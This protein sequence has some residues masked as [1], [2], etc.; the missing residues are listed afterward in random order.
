MARQL[1]TAITLAA[2][3]ALLLI[4]TLVSIEAEASPIQPPPGT[5]TTTITEA[6]IPP[7]FPPEFIP[8]LVG[9][10]ESEFTEAGSIITSKD[11]EVVVVGRYTSTPVRVVLTDL[12]GPLACNINPGWATGVYGWM[13]DNN[14]LTLTVVHDACEGRPVVLTAHPLQKE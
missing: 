14:E 6:D 1:Q 8:I 7:E 2:V 3:I 11:G 12:L 9:Q 10:W 13:F 5:Y 4:V